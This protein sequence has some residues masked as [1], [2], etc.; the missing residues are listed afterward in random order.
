MHKTRKE[1]VNLKAHAE[2]LTKK[3]AELQAQL[4]EARSHRERAEQRQE[5]LKK[6]LAARERDLSGKDVEIVRLKRC[7]LDTQDKCESLEIDLGA[8]K[9]R[10]DAAEGALNVAQTS[11][12][13]AQDNYVEAQTMLETLVNN[14]GWPQHH[15][16]I[17][18]P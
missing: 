18:I 14:S 10:A 4:D 7:L 5:E 1:N 12:N 11:L 16:I 13:V 15:G 17:H 9:E 6:Q 8:E 2:T 3:N